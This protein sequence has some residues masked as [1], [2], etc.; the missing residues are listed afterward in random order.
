VALPFRTISDVRLNKKGTSFCDQNAYRMPE[1]PLLPVFVAVDDCQASVGSVFNWASAS[2]VSDR[3][4][5]RKLLRWAGGS[6]KLSG[7]RIDAEL[8]G[9]TVLLGRYE[10]R[11]VVRTDNDSYGFAFEHATTEPAPGCE[12]ATGYSRIMTYVGLLMNR[13]LT[14]LTGYNRTSEVSSLLFDVKSTPAYHMDALPHGPPPCWSRHHHETKK[15][16]SFVLVHWLQ[17]PVCLS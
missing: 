11:A 7:F 3:N 12:S 17:H 16:T 9:Q 10:P 2:F 1:F 13:Y 6:S 5:L 4:G 15:S 8:H 14:V